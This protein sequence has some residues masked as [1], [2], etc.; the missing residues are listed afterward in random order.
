M[1]AV[2]EVAEVRRSSRRRHSAVAG[3]GIA[4][5]VALGF[6]A[7]SFGAAGVSPDRVLAVLLGG[8]DRLDRFVVLDLRLPRILAAVFVGVAFALA[9]AVFQATLRNPLASP[10]I[11]GVSTGASLGAVWAILV[12]GAGGALVAGAAFGGGLLVAFVIWLAA[13]RRGLHGVRFV[14]VGVGM[15]YL[16][17]STVAWLLARSDVRE[18]QT[19]L[20]W[21][22]GS[23]ADV[24]G[25]E[26]TALVVGTV[27]CAVALAFATRPLRALVLGDEHAVALGIRADA[28]RVVLLVIAVALV[29]MATSVA[30]PV[31]FV[32]L[33]APAIAR[34]LAGG[35][36]ASVAAA[37][38]VG[39]ALTLAADVVGQFA[40]PDFTAP[41]GVVT[42]V[43][44]APYLLWLLARTERT[45]A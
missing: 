28:A 3:I 7:L 11:L 12:L 40:I 41:L 21:T 6:T 14:L 13:W 42:G 33:I 26:L 17:G 20:H 36:G 8:G 5:V 15:A 31:A 19:A 45:R 22:V 32:A 9:G 23:V 38:A 29:A 30:G 44:G 10:D 25:D 43:I 35:G 24:R 1:T 2:V 18:A 27:A 37:G 39:A 4:V 16:C 34:R